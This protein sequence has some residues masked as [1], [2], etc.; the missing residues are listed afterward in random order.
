M[1][2]FC[3]GG[4]CKTNSCNNLNDEERERKRSAE[5][6]FELRRNGLIEADAFQP[7]QQI[8]GFARNQPTVQPHRAVVRRPRQCN[9]EQGTG[10]PP[11]CAQEG[12]TL[13]PLLGRNSS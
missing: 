10:H 13:A 1:N 7:L 9:S 4:A 2:W 8:S 6:E 12:E 5:S 3:P 11:R